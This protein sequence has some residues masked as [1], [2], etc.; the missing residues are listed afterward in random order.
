MSAFSKYDNLNQIMNRAAHQ[1]NCIG[2]QNGEPRCPCRMSNVM[3]RDGRYVQREVDLGAVPAHR[4]P[5]DTK[6]VKE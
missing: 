5:I 1:C 3:I 4:V 6:A 2:P